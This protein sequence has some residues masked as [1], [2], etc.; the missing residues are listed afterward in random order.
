MFE[1]ACGF[2]NFSLFF[3]STSSVHFFFSR[4]IWPKAIFTVLFPFRL[5]F[6]H[7]M[8]YYTALHHTPLENDILKPRQTQPSTKLNL[9]HSSNTCTNAEF[10]FFPFNISKAK[11]NNTYTPHSVIIRPFFS[12]WAS[13]KDGPLF[14]FMSCALFIRCVISLL[15]R[16]WHAKFRSTLF[17]KKSLVNITD[18]WI[19][20]F[21]SLLHFLSV[22]FNRIRFFCCKK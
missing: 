21:H 19:S 22:V 4:F 7:V 10:T 13:I 15:I 17:T 12:T 9:S 5:N 1:V 18:R 3:L 16:L 2:R 11:K 6:T 20:L 8:F 14:A